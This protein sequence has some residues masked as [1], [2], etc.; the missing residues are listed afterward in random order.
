MN[1]SERRRDE[2]VAF[3]TSATV[4]V[5]DREIVTRSTE[6]LSLQGVFVSCDEVLEP[7]MPCRIYLELSGLSS[8]LQLRMDGKVVRAVAGKGMA[9]EFT[10]IDLDSYTYLKSLVAHN[11]PDAGEENGKD[12]VSAD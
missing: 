6:D 10:S 11:R 12:F 3:A 8:R 1:E 5:E 2:R 4:V 7:G 9:I